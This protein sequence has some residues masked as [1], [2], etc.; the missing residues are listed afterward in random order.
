M[1]D[2]VTELFYNEHSGKLSSTAV[3]SDEFPVTED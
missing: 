2:S 3:S 1:S